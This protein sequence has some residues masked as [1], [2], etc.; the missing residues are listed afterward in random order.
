LKF[1]VYD[2]DAPELMQGANRTASVSERVLVRQSYAP[3]G[4]AI[5]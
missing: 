5:N 1:S 4:E 3:G 2:A